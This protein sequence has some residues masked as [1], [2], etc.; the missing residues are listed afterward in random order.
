MDASENKKKKLTDL[1]NEKESYESKAE[2]YQNLVKATDEL[3]PGEK[4]PLKNEWT[5]HLIKVSPKRDEQP[6]WKD[7]TKEIAD[8]QYVEDFWALFNNTISVSKMDRTCKVALFKKGIKPTWED[9]ANESGGNWIL[10]YTLTS[11][12]Q[13]RQHSLSVDELWRDTLLALIGDSFCGANDDDDDNDLGKNI[14]GA[15]FTKRSKDCKITLWTSCWKEEKLIRQI[16][17]TWKSLLGL[18]ERTSLTFEKFENRSNQSSN[19][20][21]SASSDSSS[22]KE[23]DYIIYKE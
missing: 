6:V 4:W 20:L 18:D 8:I 13:A 16:G 10:K 11:T 23:T 17:R 9:K 3:Y 12:D 22:K 21:L 1:V 5:F 15:L 7:S 19:P 2:F 14:C